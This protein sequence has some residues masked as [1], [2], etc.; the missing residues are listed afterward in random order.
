MNAYR[1][2]ARLSAHLENIR[3]ASRLA[4]IVIILLTFIGTALIVCVRDYYA[5]QKRHVVEGRRVVD[6]QT[7]D[8]SAKGALHEV[9][10]TQRH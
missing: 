10:D 3:D 4:K 5:T 1:D 8:P 7:K 9:G 2:V 6:A